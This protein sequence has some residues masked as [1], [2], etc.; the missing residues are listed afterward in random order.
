MPQVIIIA[1][2]TADRVIG[3]NN[4]LPWNIPEEMR[5][6]RRTTAGGTVLMG[7][8]TYESIGHPLPDRRNIIV[9]KTLRSVDGAEVY[10]SF[11]QGLEKA[12][13]YGKDV[14][15]IGGA[16]IYAQALPLADRM[17]LSYIKGSYSGDTY[18]PDFDEKEWRVEGREAFEKFEVVRYL[19]RR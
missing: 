2:M 13:G 8:K 15:V 1:A 10:R 12:K 19:R 18:F 14:F 4:A 7:R 6:F 16:T 3:K 5:H 17:I 11:E 9:S